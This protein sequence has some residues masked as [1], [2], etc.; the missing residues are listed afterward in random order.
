[1]MPTPIFVMALLAA[2]RAR[3]GD[4]AATQAPTQAP[5]DR[6]ASI[7]LVWNAGAKPAD[8]PHLFHTKER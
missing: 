1:M 8:S 7:R 6:R 5:K 4:E 2:H 3:S